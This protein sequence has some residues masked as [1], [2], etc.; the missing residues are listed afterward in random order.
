MYKCPFSRCIQPLKTA[1]PTGAIK[2]VTNNSSLEKD[3]ST[4]K[5]TDKQQKAD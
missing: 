1:A 2:A 5:V 3:N 4:N